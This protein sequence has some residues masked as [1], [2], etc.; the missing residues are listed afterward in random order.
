MTEKDFIGIL[1]LAT[2]DNSEKEKAKL[3]LKTYIDNKDWE[4]LK[5]DPNF[6]NR[7]SKNK[8]LLIS[9]YL[10]I[11]SL[12]KNKNLIKDI[13]LQKIRSILNLT[14]NFITKLGVYIKYLPIH[15]LNKQNPIEIFINPSKEFIE[16]INNVVYLMNIE[17]GVFKKKKLEKLSSKEY[18]H[19]LD[20]K[21]L[22]TLENTTGLEFLVRKFNEYGLEKLIKVNYM[23]SNIKVNKT[24]FPELYE[25]LC[26][27]CE[28]LNYSPIPELYIEHGLINAKTLGT[29]NPIIV[30]TSSCVSSMT[31]DELLFV[32]GHEIGHLKSQHVLYHQIADLFPIITNIIGSLTLGVG[33]IISTG[34]EIALLNWK[35][36]SEFT[37]DRAGLLACQNI[38]AAITAMMKIGGAPSKYYNELNPYEFKKQAMSFKTLNDKNLEK[39]AKFI[40]VL[41]AD[42]PW[43]VER[44]QELYKWVDSGEFEKVIQR[45]TQN[46][47]NNITK[48]K[49][50]FCANCGLPFSPDDHFCAN[51]GTIR[52]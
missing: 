29:E 27:A 40:S 11:Y 13:K 16:W 31:Y 32:L 26:T 36:K 7:L 37:A 17:G 48:F 15:S 39:F 8:L 25:I 3:F 43:T 9:L 38:D 51:C 41:F 2:I 28:V 30:I 20:R 34:L 47:S 19:I 23:G 10:H 6:V 21:A 42:H 22:E 49:D 18:E 12:L 50:K 5:I 46:I 4:N 14:D 1:I 33:N 45:Q 24:N 35:R 52:H 44:A